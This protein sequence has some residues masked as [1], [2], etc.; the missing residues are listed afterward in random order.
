MTRLASLAVLAL[1]ASACASPRATIRSMP[2]ADL[3]T[4]D[5]IGEA[6]LV[7]YIAPWLALTELDF[8]VDDDT[9]PSRLELGASTLWAGSCTDE[10]GD[11]WEPGAKLVRLRPDE[12]RAGYR[13][14]PLALND[15]ARGRMRVWKDGD[16]TRFSITLKLSDPDN[17]EDVL[18]IDY[19]GRTTVDLLAHE[20][21]ISREDQS[22]VWS[23]FGTIASTEHGKIEVLTFEKVYDPSICPNE[24]ISGITQLRANGHTLV[25]TYDGE[26]DCDDPGH[27][28]WTLDGEP[29]GELRVID[30]ACSMTDD[31]RGWPL[32][33]LIPLVAARRRA[34]RR[35]RSS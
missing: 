27:A 26:L 6:M 34:R 35:S 28:R 20:P 22:G 29:M 12:L 8:E 15:Q 4:L 10:N 31:P 33:V 18:V 7:E 16:H 32:L 2:E 19:Q 21:P 23:G 9:C 24:P 14:F 3:T 1:T 11:W 25:I 17:E 30:L 5:P 13:D